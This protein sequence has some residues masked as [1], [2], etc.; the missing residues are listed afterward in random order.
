MYTSSRFRSIAS[1]I[2]VSNWPARPTNGMPWMSSS[3]P[4]AS[5]MN[6]SAACG[7]PTP[8]T[9]CRRPR[10]CS[11]QRVQS[12]RSS[13]TCVERFCGSACPRP[14]AQPRAER[15]PAPAC[16]SAGAPPPR[17]VAAHPARRPSPRTGAGARR[18][19]SARPCRSWRTRHA[20]PPGLS[21]KQELRA[22]ENGDGHRCLRLQRQRLLPSRANQ[23]DDVRVDLEAGARAPARRSPR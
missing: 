8:N 22:I 5:P 1:M 18:V 7:L 17:R 11:L 15:W 19:P 2:F 20:A 9:I 23:G 14:P 10:R 12:P 16:A 3:C 6:I 13:R 4:G 21:A